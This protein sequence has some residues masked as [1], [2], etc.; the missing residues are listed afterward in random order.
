MKEIGIA[1]II[2]AKR[3]EKGI[4]QDE[5]AS[6]MGVTKASVS[7]WETGQSYPDI[8]LLPRLAAYFNVSI[9]EL[10]DYTPQLTKEDIRRIY[11]QLASEF[12]TA[13][14]PEAKAKCE[15]YIRK[16]YSCFPF[17]LQMAILYVNHHMLAG[18][19]DNVKQTLEDAINLCQRIRSESDDPSLLQEAVYIEAAI[20]QMLNRPE[21]MLELLGDE[22]KPEMSGSQLIISA[23]QM[24]GNQPKA[25]Q[26]AQIYVYNLLGGLLSV[27]PSYM[28]LYME[29][30]PRL[31]EIIR[32]I[33]GTIELFHA[34]KIQANACVLF[35]YNAAVLLMNHNQSDLA[36][37]MLE[38]YTSVCADELA[39]VSLHGDDF[40]DLL[41]TWFEDLELGNRAPR[42]QTA[43]NKDILSV[44]CQTEA[45]QALKG[46]ERYQ[47][48]V[49]LLK[50]TLNL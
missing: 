17:L 1:K 26:L 38:H 21:R 24:L 49:Q 42:S 34:D 8:L 13:P 14:F 46:E 27:M 41:D 11:H 6:C 9:D 22:I 3:R 48:M 43:I 7:K 36:L 4:T 31:E 20:N 50:R 15:V 32:R 39:S 2:V 44:L 28:Q 33:C 37:D 18:S 5:L 40:F 47:H 19:H 45:F 30:L 12:S 35:Y 16:Y 23:F 10:M 29:D 25:R